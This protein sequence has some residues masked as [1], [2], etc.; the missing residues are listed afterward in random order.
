MLMYE[1]S[2]ETIYTGGGF[3]LNNSS[4]DHREIIDRKAAE[5]WRF[6]GYV[7]AEFTSNG[8]TKSLDLIFERTISE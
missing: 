8:G 1:Y 7:P 6:V 3:W 2:Y 5:G 4:C